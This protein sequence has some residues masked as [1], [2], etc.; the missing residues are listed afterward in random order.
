MSQISDFEI[1]G[2]DCPMSIYPASAVP[3]VITQPGKRGAVYLDDNYDL[4]VT[5]IVDEM[6]VIEFSDIQKD[7][8]AG[9]DYRRH[10]LFAMSVN[11]IRFYEVAD[12]AIFF[13]KIL[14][15]KNFSQEDPFVRAHFAEATKNKKIIIKERIICKRY[16]KEKAEGFLDLLLRK[17]QEKNIDSLWSE[18]R[19]SLQINPYPSNLEIMEKKLS[20]RRG[21]D[22][23]WRTN[24]QKHSDID[25]SNFISQPE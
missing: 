19:K 11:D 2:Y 12:E 21:L 24:K 15:D 10:R 17:T 4:Q 9:F 22:D 23:L 20:E 1:I 16:L 14:S 18:H 6:N 7:Q 25:E 5:P 3:I 8:L 13:T